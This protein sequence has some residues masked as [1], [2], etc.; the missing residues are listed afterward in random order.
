MVVPST[1]AGAGA[2]AEGGQGDRDGTGAGQVAY[3]AELVDVEVTAAE[4]VADAH[5]PP[6]EGPGQFTAIESVPPKSSGA[7]LCKELAAYKHRDAPL[8]N[9]CQSHARWASTSLVPRASYR[10]MSTVW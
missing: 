9:L 3:D 8:W 7:C 2:E 5:R 6:R 1:G 4:V 10:Q